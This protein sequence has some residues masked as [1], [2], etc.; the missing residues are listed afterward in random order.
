MKAESRTSF[1]S[2]EVGAWIATALAENAPVG[3]STEPHLRAAILSVANQPGKLTRARLILGVTQAHGIE[4]ETGLALATAVEYFHLSSL[5]LDDLPCMDDAKTRRGQDC[6]HRSHGEATAILAALAFI[7][8]AYALIGFAVSDQPLDVRLQ[9]QACLDAYLGV[10][11]LVGGQAR[12]LRFAESD[13]SSRE[14]ACV[15][16]GKTGA[17]FS[18]SILLPALLAGP[19]K[20]ERHALKAL[21]IYWSLIYQALDDLQD[22]LSTSVNAG[23][24]TG[25][26]R[27]LTRPNVALTLGVPRT[28]NRLSRLLHRGDRTIEHLCQKS[29]SWTFLQEFQHYLAEAAAPI[30]ALGA[31]SAA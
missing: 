8:R 13:R 26:D 16:V 9:V 18:L 6:V 3:H 23:K 31:A 17:L 28:L 15:A 21:C 24:T 5:L 12:D 14:T 11:G 1:W 30:V 22:V 2:N 27:L 19:S 7:N 20:S 4:H 10:S 25:R 29:L